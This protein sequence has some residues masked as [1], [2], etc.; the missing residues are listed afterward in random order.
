MS[1]YG[2]A[3]ISGTDFSEFPFALAV[4]NNEGYAILFTEQ[5][6]TYSIKLE[7]EQ[8]SSSGSSLFVVNFTIAEDPETGGYEASADKTLVEIQDAY[9]S[10][11]IIIARGMMGTTTVM[12]FPLSIIDT[13]TNGFAN[14]IVIDIPAEEGRITSI[15]KATFGVDGHGAY[16]NMDIKE[17]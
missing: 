1:F 9:R 4:N 14:F 10:G 5:A 13:G 6:G 17:V 2:G 11:A 7:A 16:F 12:Q 3:T 8:S 15:E